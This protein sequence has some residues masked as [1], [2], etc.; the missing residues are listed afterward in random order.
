MPKRKPSARHYKH[1]GYKRFRDG[2]GCVWVSIAEVA[3]RTGRDTSTV[4]RWIRNN[5]VR[6]QRFGLGG[7]TSPSYFLELES[8]RKLLGTAADVMD[9]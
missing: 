1:Q 3:D 4:Y 8:L 7:G 6:W 9:V 5:H 2:L